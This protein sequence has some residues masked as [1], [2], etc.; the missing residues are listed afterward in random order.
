MPYVPPAPRNTKPKEVINFKPVESEFPQLGGSNASKSAWKGRSFAELADDWN[1]EEKD[2]KLMAE[3]EAEREVDFV[4]PRFN[5]V[6]R[7]VD[8]E[9]KVETKPEVKQEWTYVEN[10]KFHKKKEV[11][12]DILYPEIDETAQ[13]SVWND[14]PAA[15]ETV[16]DERRG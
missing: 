2:K 8:E 10:R 13:D 3:K 16:W 11:D 9:E 14:G 12:L 1:K 15:H 7:F 6:R 5:N 4:L